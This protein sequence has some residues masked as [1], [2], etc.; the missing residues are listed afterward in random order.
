MNLPELDRVRVVRGV[1]QVDF[2]LVAHEETLES[3]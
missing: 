3:R 1:G 2:E